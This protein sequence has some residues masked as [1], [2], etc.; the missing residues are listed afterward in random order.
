MAKVTE[1]YLIDDITGDRIEEGGTVEFGLDGKSYEIDLHDKH[2]EALRTALAGFIAA[3]RRV[4]TEKGVSTARKAPSGGSDREFNQ[5]VRAWAR[6]N[7][8]EV[9]ERGRIKQEVLDQYNERDLRRPEPP[10]T[11]EAPAAPSGDD[12]TTQTP[13]DPQTPMTDNPDAED[14]PDSDDRVLAWWT[15]VLKNKRPTR[16]KVTGPMRERYRAEVLNPQ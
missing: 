12:E 14:A 16:G 4:A 3:A 11:D 6:E 13:Q 15:G 9:S 1:V 5:A 7:G 2:A 10:T 8:I